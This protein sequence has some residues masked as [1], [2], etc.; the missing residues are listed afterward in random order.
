MHLTQEP[1]AQCQHKPLLRQDSLPPR[2]QNLTPNNPNLLH[3]PIA[4]RR[5]DTAQP[6]HNLHA[7]DHVA[8]DSVGSIQMPR[9][10][11]SDEELASV[12]VWARVGHAENPGC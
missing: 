2:P 10:G 7:V 6:L 11:Q 4:P 8:E 3:R 12:G 5:L 9:R 1:P